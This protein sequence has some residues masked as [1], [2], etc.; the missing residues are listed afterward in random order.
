MK[1]I[2][3][4]LLFLAL[5][6]YNSSA[7]EIIQQDDVGFSKGKMT[8]LAWMVGFWKGPG[9]NGEC[10]ELWMPQQD[11]TM[12]GVF[13]YIEE[14]KL[15]F[16]EYMAIAEEAGKINLKVKHFSANFSPWEEKDEWINFPLIKTEG[17]T[18]YFNGLTIQRVGDQMTIKLSMKHDGKSSITTFEYKKVNL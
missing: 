15:I 6:H 9:L 10:E 2:L 11:N 1:N 4:S 5:V 12:M 3:F 14:G 18:A 17:Q 16:T 7:Q 8:D 13:R